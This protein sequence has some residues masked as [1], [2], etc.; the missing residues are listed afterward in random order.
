MPLD[1]YAALQTA[2]LNWLARPA[3]PLV[4]G[5]IPD[6]IKL[7]ETEANRRLRVIGAEAM[8]DVYGG[9][10]PLDLPADFQELRKAWIDGGP[11]LEYIAPGNAGVWGYTGLPRY[12]TIVGGGSGGCGSGEG[13]QLMLA[14]SPAQSTC[15]VHLLYQRGV[16]ALSDTNT[17]NWLLAAAPD[18]YLFG[19]LGEAELFIGHDE[20]AVLWGQRREL[21]FASLEAADR[22]ARWGGAPLTIRADMWT[23]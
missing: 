17:T 9:T 3:D 10:G 20:R 1:S 13:A 16:P 12:Y 5:S 15:L 2:V 19:T 11:P 7:F 21:A 8:D 14:P 6:M 23:P 22:K 18:A 4:S